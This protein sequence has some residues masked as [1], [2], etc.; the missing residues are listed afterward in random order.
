MSGLPGL[1]GSKDVMLQFET[2]QEY[3]SET[4]VNDCASDEEITAYMQQLVLIVN[5]SEKQIE[6]QD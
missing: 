1:L 4:E 2:C 5:L 3:A 6:Y